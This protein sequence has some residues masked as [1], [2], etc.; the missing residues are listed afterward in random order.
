MR[1]TVLGG[2]E[3]GLGAARLAKSKGF[4]VF[5]S[6]RG[7]IKDSIKNILDQYDIPFEEGKHNEKDILKSDEVI[8]SPGIPLTVPLVQKIKQQ[9]IPLIGEIEF[10]FRHASGTIIAI[11]GSNGKTTTTKLTHHLLTT[12]GLHCH[13]GGNIGHSFAGLIAE[14]AVG[15][16]VLELS[17]FQLDTIQH[18]RP[19]I[20]A[21]LNITPD[22]LDRYE[23]KMKLYAASKFRITH[24]LTFEDH[25]LFNV[26]N[27]A[28]IENLAGK[29][30]PSLLYPISAQYVIENHINVFGQSYSINNASLLG[31][32]NAMNALF[33]ITIA[34][35]MGISGELIQ[36]GLDDFVNVPHRMELVKNINGIQ[37]INDSKATNVDA[38]F[39]ALEA[40]QSPIIWLVG[41]Q[42]KGNDYRSLDALV[43]QKVKY[44]ICLGLDNESIIQHFS[45]LNVPISDTNSIKTAISL[46]NSV[47]N[48]G[49]VVLLSP[50]CASFDLFKNYEDRGNQFKDLIHQLEEY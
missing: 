47:A 23:G 46:A 1:I 42:D 35:I 29:N 21:I 7:M 39:Y 3:S 8:I 25:F 2:G 33:A 34:R 6:D 32:H 13:L 44:I 31:R 38:T 5:L 15:P 30:W 14:Q 9:Q 41:G 28:I 27:P 36:K 49:D 10:A 24:N 4:D 20:A 26:D 22:H 11:T 19:H 43:K 45:R 12:G 16:F 40:V 37:Y 50:A 48:E 17:S 18:F